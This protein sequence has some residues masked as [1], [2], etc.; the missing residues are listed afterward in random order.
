MIVEQQGD[1]FV[2]VDGGKQIAGPSSTARS[3]HEKPV[4]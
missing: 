4:H 3:M 1:E 2:V